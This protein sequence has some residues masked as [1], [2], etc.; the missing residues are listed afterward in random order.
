[1]S[2]HTFLSYNSKNTPEA[3]KIH[4]YLHNSGVKVFFDKKVI[5]LGD[6]FQKKLEEGLLASSSI[7]VLI[8]RGGIGPWQETETY[9]SQIV[10]VARTKTLRTIPVFLPGANPQD[11]NLG[12]PQF[13]N[14]FH[15]L[16]FDKSVDE[17]EKIQELISSMPPIISA[18]EYE[19]PL[20]DVEESTFLRNSIKFYENNYE[21]FYE[22]WRNEYPI[23]PMES[24][25]KRVRDY[26]KKALI[27]DAGCGPG[28]HS[29]Y[30]AERGHS[31]LGV[32]MCSNFINIANK[33]KH[34][35]CSFLHADLRKLHENFG[36]RNAYDAIWAC[37]SCVHIS[38]EYFDRQLSKFL[39]AIRPKGVIGLTL[40]V[41]A[42]SVIQEDGRFFE[43][44]N[45]DDIHKR[46]ESAGFNIVSTTT[47]LD[48]QSTTTDKKKVKKWHAVIALA[49]DE[50]QK[51]VP[52]IIRM[53]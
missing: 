29:K 47:E 25:L 39:A 50:K 27:L 30:F 18:S 34:S 3:T 45:I 9:M 33:N 22:K 43:R 41:E 37:G 53:N 49:P 26:T 44:Y 36:A 1:M 20:L 4:E 15:R 5:T 28:H 16:I 21:Q 13:L 46:F 12:M 14:L 19:R 17:I 23:A 31:V 51:L 52:N 2:Y 10:D 40:Q 48:N 32:D 24:F 7:I 11:P 42:P 38:R 35:D 8:G 6:P